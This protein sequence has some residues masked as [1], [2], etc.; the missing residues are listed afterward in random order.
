MYIKLRLPS[1]LLIF[2]LLLSLFSCAGEIP[3]NTTKK[4]DNKPND[5]NTENPDPTQE[6]PKHDTNEKLENYHPLLWK[7]S[8]DQGHYMYLFVTLEAADAPI[9]PLPV[10]VWNAYYDSVAFLAE[11]DVYSF[12]KLFEKKDDENA[13]KQLIE[14]YK[15]LMYMDD[16]IASHLSKSAYTAATTIF[17]QYN[18]THKLYEYYNPIFWMDKMDEIIIRE[19]GLSDQYNTDIHMIEQAMKDDKL[20]SLMRMDEKAVMQSKLSDKL[21]EYM[22]SSYLEEGA[23]DKKIEQMKD[24]YQAWIQGDK[25]A[26]E[27]IFAA[28]LF[29]EI[30]ATPAHGETASEM[31]TLYT[32]YMEKYYTPIM[33]DVF[34]QVK[35]YLDG[36]YTIFCSLHASWL[37]RNDGL[38]NRLFNAGYT[39]ELMNTDTEQ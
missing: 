13:Q 1:L 5:H 36:G 14:Y 23:I 27:T 21:Q 22:L 24:G 20:I 19:S 18:L 25:A 11:K 4:P 3:D 8:D 16:T 9:F 30:P 7:V 2:V 28:P 26:L 35:G 34:E 17:T 32:E 12:E 6:N 10:A 39:V 33:N 37:L 15:K 38:I 29:P 31:Y